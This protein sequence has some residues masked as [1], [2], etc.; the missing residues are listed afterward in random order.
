[1]A[2]EELLTI[3][4]SVRDERKMAYQIREKLKKL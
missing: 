2:A 3:K 4:V 1:M